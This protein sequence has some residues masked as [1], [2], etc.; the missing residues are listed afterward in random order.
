[1]CEMCAFI[2]R[3]NQAAPLLLEYGKRIEGLWSGYCTGIGVQDADGTLR[4]HKTLGW[5][6]QWEERFDP[7][8]LPGTIGFFHSRTGYP[9]MPGDQRYAHPFLTSDASGMVVSQGALGIFTDRSAGIPRIGNMLL[10]KGVRFSSADASVKE[11]FQ[12]LEDGTRVHMSDVV[13]EYA[14]Y[15]LKQCGD[16]L[17]AVRRTG[18]DILEESCS[19]FLFREFPGHLYIIN[20]N[21]RLCICFHEDGISVSTCALAFGKERVNLMEVPF[22]SVLDLTAD[23]IRMEKLSERIQVYREIPPNLHEDFLAWTAGNPETMLAQVM[24]NAL[25]LRY[26]PGVL[27]HVPT[28]EIFE[29]FY[30]DGKLRLETREY[31]GITENVSSIRTT[32]TLNRQPTRKA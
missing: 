25:K 3:R 18:C 22:N 29:Q 32:F 30:Y 31:P 10:K 14:A 9:G 26:P 23:S 1:M 12:L 2:G 15:Q 16:P 8:S 20:M 17:E 28:H 13:G 7:A 11:R 6:R 4:M 5:S 24:D 27:R 21:Q 19:L